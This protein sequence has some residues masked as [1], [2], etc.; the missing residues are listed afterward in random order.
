MY[1]LDTNVISELRRKEH[2]KSHPNVVRW[3]ESVPKNELYLSVISIY[4]IELGA[5]RI[6]RRDPLQGALF[7]LWLE[8]RVLPSFRGHILTLDQSSARRAGLLHVPNPR[9]ERDAF[10]AATAIEHGMTVVSRNT[11]DFI[12]TGVKTLNPW[13]FQ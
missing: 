12:P 10:I 9:P 6:E 7:L 1:L 11:S 2:G 4:E 3:E 8:K 5:R 13:E